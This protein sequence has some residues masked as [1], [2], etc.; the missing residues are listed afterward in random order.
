MVICTSVHRSAHIYLNLSVFP[1]CFIPFIC[2]LST[3]SE[4][5]GFVVDSFL[6]L[7]GVFRG[8]FFLLCLLILKQIRLWNSCD[9][10]DQCAQAPP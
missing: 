2:N 3:K 9:C 4:C 6:W 10:H 1:T 7:V 5:R 8:C